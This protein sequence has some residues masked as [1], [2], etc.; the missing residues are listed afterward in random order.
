[1]HFILLLPFSLLFLYLSLCLCTCLLKSRNHASQRHSRDKCRSLVH[2]NHFPMHLN[3][4]KHLP[5]HLP[6][7]ITLH[8]GI[9]EINA[10]FRA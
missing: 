4:H 5:L 7:E 3:W 9:Q 8:S 2:K 6:S 1:M 10:A